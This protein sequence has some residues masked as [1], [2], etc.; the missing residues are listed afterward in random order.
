MAHQER[1]DLPSPPAKSLLCWCAS[2][3]L[4]LLKPPLLLSA[5]STRHREEDITVSLGGRWS[6]RLAPLHHRH[7]LPLVYLT[8]RLFQSLNPA[9][10]QPPFA[11]KSS[12]IILWRCRWLTAE[13]LMCNFAKHFHCSTLN[14]F[15]L[16]GRLAIRWTKT[17]SSAWLWVLSHSIGN[18]DLIKKGK[19]SS[20]LSLKFSSLW[21]NLSLLSLQSIFFVSSIYLSIYGWNVYYIY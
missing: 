3:S 2:L 9:R 8:M 14:M 7:A 1:P 12:G 4:R 15:R 11:T 17:A 18:S 13:E 6:R 21:V 16:V 20:H 10:V 5:L 19:W